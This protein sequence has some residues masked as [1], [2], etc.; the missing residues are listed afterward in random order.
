M[1]IIQGDNDRLEEQLKEIRASRALRN[2]QRHP[3]VSEQTPP[4]EPEKDV[5]Q[6]PG[7]EMLRL[8]PGF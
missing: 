5:R 1:I 4:S 3:S 8:Q 7:G 2:Q 6:I